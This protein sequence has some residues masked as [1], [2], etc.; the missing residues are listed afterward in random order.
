TFDGDGNL[1]S[2]WRGDFAEGHGITLVNEGGVEYLWIVDHG[3]KNHH[4]HGYQNPPGVG[5]A[6]GQVF[7][8]TLDGEVVMRLETPPLPVY[9]DKRYSPTDIAVNEERFGGNGDIWVADGYGAYHV[10]R[11]TKGGEHVSSINGEEGAGAYDCPHGVFID[12]RKSE[13]EL[14][15]ADRANNRVQVYDTE[16]GFR[17]MFGDDFLTLPSCFAA[18]GDLMI[19]AEL[20]A[21]LTVVDKNDELLTHIGDNQ[22]VCDVEGWPNNVNESGQSVRTSLLETGKFNSPHG[23]AADANGNLYVAEWL[24][25]GRV[26]R[27]NRS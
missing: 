17:R 24:I 11:F 6:P 7:K 18:H 25:G 27:L 3:G 2:S 26:T 13:P 4:L 14:Y 16:G 21:R 8:T 20:R 23:L 9:N 10:H 12:F 22:Q 19:I 15:V 1:I 5:D